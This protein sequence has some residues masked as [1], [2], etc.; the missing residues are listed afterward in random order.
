MGDKV[1]I[2]QQNYVTDRWMKQT[3]VSNKL[4]IKHLSMTCI[5][6]SESENPSDTANWF[7]KKTSL[8]NDIFDFLFRLLFGTSTP[9][10]KPLC[11]TNSLTANST[12]KRSLN[13]ND[14][15]L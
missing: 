14:L 12:T 15:F 3:R 9:T 11:T 4:S 5:Q 6:Y 2:M 10:E 7:R 1:A 13:R 8:K